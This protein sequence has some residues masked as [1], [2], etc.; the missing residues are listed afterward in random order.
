MAHTLLPL[1]DVLKRR[2]KSRSA[3][4]LDIRNGLFVPPVKT[5]VRSRR[6]PD[7]EVDVLIAACIAGKS[8][9]E[10]RR[11]VAKLEAARKA[12]A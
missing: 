12:A 6:Y 4:Y 8:N 5:G 9:D 11:L 1:P 7:D 2:S 3:H 10:I